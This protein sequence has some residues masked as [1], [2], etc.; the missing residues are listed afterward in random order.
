MMTQVKQQV[1]E[2]SCVLKKYR[3][4]FSKNMAKGLRMVSGTSSSQK[5]VS[6]YDELDN[7]KGQLHA[8]GIE[9]M[10]ASGVASDPSWLTT[11]EQMGFS[12]SEVL[13]AAG[14]LGDNPTPSQIDDLMEVLLVMNTSR[15]ASARPEPPLPP[16]LSSPPVADPLDGVLEALEELP[17]LPAMTAVGSV[18]FE[19]AEDKDKIL[20]ARSRSR[21]PAETSSALE[22][23]GFTSAAIQE[24]ALLLGPTA[25][26]ADLF[27]L[28]ITMA[29]KHGGSW[30]GLP[31]DAIPHMSSCPAASKAVQASDALQNRLMEEVAKARAES[32]M[33]MEVEEDED[34]ALPR[35]ARDSVIN[36][37]NAEVEVAKQNAREALA[38]AL[39]GEEEE[40]DTHEVSNRTLASTVIAMVLAQ[41]SEKMVGEKSLAKK[42]ITEEAFPASPTR[43]GA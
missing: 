30:A 29:P 33:C 11:V 10:S 38:A 20:H 37:T 16:P 5:D 4:V 1:Q 24:A 27:D 25:Q 12:R 34:I 21:L 39:F 41:I 32:S 40:E 26:F 42:H 19:M 8:T 31:S 3:Q 22:Q 13:E 28:L 36:R 14:P 17:P 23:M 9:A 6:V 15:A 7:N 43:G 35:S 2:T 18:E